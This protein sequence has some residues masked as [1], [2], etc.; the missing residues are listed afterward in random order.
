V[1]RKGFIIVWAFLMLTG[2]MTYAQQPEG[3]SGIG[4]AAQPSASP[5]AQS[6]PG[7]AAPLSAATSATP[8][9]VPATPAVSYPR[10]LSP[11]QIESAT[12]A[13]SPAQQKA[14]QAEMN[15]TGGTLTPEA[16]EAL[17]AKP[18]LQGLKPEEV[19]KGKELLEKKKRRLKTKKRRKA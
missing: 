6:V 16:I 18:E 8:S 10:Q 17:K 19:I 14:V 12:K 7:Q 15:K 9:A 3:G 13:L 5:S 11:Q 1:I 4:V 2:S